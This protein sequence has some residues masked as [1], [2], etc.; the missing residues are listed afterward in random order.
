M[1]LRTC[2]CVR[3]CT[4]ICID[5]DNYNCNIMLYTRITRTISIDTYVDII[6]I[7]L[8][9]IYAWPWD[10]LI[11]TWDFDQCILKLGR[12]N[13]ERGTS[14]GQMWREISICANTGKLGVHAG[15]RLGK[16]NRA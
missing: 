3:I 6:I 12:K 14:T 1:H 8:S 16:N 13:Q 15:K 4:C 2:A 10:F 7:H 9:I 5:H 11:S